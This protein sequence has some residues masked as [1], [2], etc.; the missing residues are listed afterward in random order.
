MKKLAAML[1]G[2]TTYFLVVLIINGYEN[3][4]MHTSINEAIVDWFWYRSPT[5]YLPN[6]VTIK[7]GDVT[8][9]GQKVV[10]GGKI[11]VNESLVK[12][13]PKEWVVHGGYSADEPQVPASLRHFY[14]PVSIDGVSYLTDLVA[15]YA[16]TYNQPLPKMN[17]KDWALS[18]TDNPYNWNYAKQY[19]GNA[20]Y[21]ETNRSKYL[22]DAFRALGEVLHLFAD[23]GCPPH[24]RN[25]A[26]PAFAN[27]YVGDPDP[28]EELIKSTQ[29]LDYGTS[30]I[31]ADAN[32][33]AQFKNATTASNLF[34]VMAT[35]TNKNFFSEDTQYG[36]NITP[37]INDRRSYTSPAVGSDVIYNSTDNYYYKT[38]NGKQIKMLQSKSYLFGLGSKYTTIDLECVKSQASV[39]IPTI[40]EGGANLIKLFLP[41][42]SV[43]IT[44]AKD[45]GSFSGVVK[46]T[47]NAEYTK[48]IKYNGKIKILKGTANVGDATCTNNAIAGSGLNLKK[49]DKILA[50]LEIGGLIFTSNEFTVKTASGG[51]NSACMNT[52]KA[53]KFINTTLDLEGIGKDGLVVW[54]TFHVPINTNIHQAISSSDIQTIKW[55]GNTF[56]QEQTIA[57]VHNDPNAILYTMI[58]DTIY[59]K[60]EGVISADASTIQSASVIWSQ[61]SSGYTTD[62]S[63]KMRDEYLVSYRVINMPSNTYCGGF[64]LSDNDAINKVISDIKHSESRIGYTKNNSTGLYQGPSVYIDKELTKITKL[65]KLNLSFMNSP[66]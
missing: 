20:F 51:D 63:F 22:G 17:A 62:K 9:D 14:D 7:L 49:D 50:Q 24:V 64:N 42:I 47:L 30:N 52:I 65:K 2:F 31:S 57:R 40:V 53:R 29:V 41:K 26:H 34:E 15:N 12:L 16:I 3:T 58:Y 33:A 61:K 11:N 56:I 48:E 44:D 35:F 38:I 39:L 36:T 59:F 55:S 32:T 18:A 27:G 5:N 10:Q 8:V 60:I 28:Y 43:E 21:N 23:M 4:K 1:I 66:F 46:H 45:D 37:H 25:D 19:L 6:N 54:K 13:T